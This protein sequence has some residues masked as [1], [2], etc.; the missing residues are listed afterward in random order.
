MDGLPF[1]A[2]RPESGF[3]IEALDDEEKKRVLGAFRKY[4]NLCSE[5]LWLK[6]IGR[7]D[8]R[9]WSV[10]EVGIKEIARFPS[11]A[12]AWAELRCEYEYYP[13]FCSFM[14]GLAP[15]VEEPPA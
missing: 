14:D 12:Y 3:D 4:F 5:E 8:D 2:R 13:V 10:W 6:N 1:D 15:K 9:T 11:F 7:I